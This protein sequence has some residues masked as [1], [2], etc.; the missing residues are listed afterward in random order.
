M[1]SNFCFLLH[2]L[3]FEFLFQIHFIL[4]P[5]SFKI[6]S[7][8]PFSPSP[9]RDPS[10][11][12]PSAISNQHQNSDSSAFTS[13]SSTVLPYNNFV[14]TEASNFATLSNIFNPIDIP[15]TNSSTMMNSAAPIDISYQRNNQFNLQ[16][17]FQPT[18][19][20]FRRESMAHS[21]GMGGI[22]WGGASVGSWLRDE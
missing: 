20:R 13:P 14:S 16:S 7:P 19:Q 9:S 6:Q 5:N 22:S 2:L 11:L 8:F 17:N 10:I 3:L 18:Q 21:Q 15:P 12:H 1:F 4:F